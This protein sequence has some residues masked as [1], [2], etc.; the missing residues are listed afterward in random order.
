[1][2]KIF[3]FRQKYECDFVVQE[4][5][6]YF[7]IQACYTLNDAETKERELRALYE[8]CHFLGTN[9]GTVITFDT[10]EKT[11]YKNIDVEILPFYEY[12]L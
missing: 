11:S 10:K 4:G 9:K 7:P 6:S 5:S 3:Y 2:K 8:A 12:F 1:M